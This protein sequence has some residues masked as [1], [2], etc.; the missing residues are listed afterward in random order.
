MHIITFV[1]VIVASLGALYVGAMV[2]AKAFTFLAL[3][4]Q[5]LGLFFWNKAS[6]K[7][8][9]KARSVQAVIKEKAEQKAKAV[10][11]AV[12]P[13]PA[14]EQPTP[15]KPVDEYAYLEIPTYIRKGK[16]LVW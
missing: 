8:S 11:T 16:T 12:V 3:Q 9:N 4:F 10:Q 6:N 1:F 15:A 14:Q 13:E 2:F 7:A 5:N